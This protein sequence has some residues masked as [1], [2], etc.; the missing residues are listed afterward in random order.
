MRDKYG[1][2]YRRHSHGGD[3][4][5]GEMHQR[6]QAA[7][8]RKQRWSMAKQ[9]SRSLFIGCLAQ[10]SD[11]RLAYVS[12]RSREGSLISCFTFRLLLALR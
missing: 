4:D 9:A 10:E 7:V 3:N 5:S 2:L 11:E 6:R 12:K 1:H 8:D